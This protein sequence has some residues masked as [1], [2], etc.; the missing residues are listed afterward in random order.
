MGKSTSALILQRRGVSV[1]DSDAIAREIVEPGQPALDEIRREFGDAVIDASGN[2]GRQELARIVFGDEAARK[3][4]EAILH[5]RIRKIWE[6][7]LKAWQDAGHATAVAMIPLL[8]E[9]DSAG[10]FHATICVACS[11]STQRCRLR[12]RGWTDQEID[13]RNRAQMPIEKKMA[14]ADFVVWTEGTL[15]AHEAQL[16]RI[17]G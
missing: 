2:L 5:P 12:E 11:E 16:Q 7:Q 1:V 17:I 3:R 6:A 10:A 9:T 14:L 4:L 13:L 15:A 8:F